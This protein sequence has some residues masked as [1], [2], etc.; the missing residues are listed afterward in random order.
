M[1]IKVKLTGLRNAAYYS[2]AVG[3]VVEIKL[4]EYLRGVVAAEMGNA[5]LE[6]CKAQ[7]VASRT[8]AYPYYSVGKVISDSSRSVQCFNAERAHS[9]QYPNAFQAVADTADEV[10]QYNGKVIVPCSFSSSN[11]GRTTSSQERWGGARAWLI[12]QKDEWDFAAT[13]GKK[14]GHGVGMSQAGAKYAAG[15]GKS[16]EEILTFYYPNTTLH[17]GVD[18]MA[19][20]T[21]KASYL[22][23]S[24]KTM[25]LPWC[26]P[27]QPWKYVASGASEGAVDC[28]GAFTYWYKQAGSF[29]YHGSNTMWRKYTTA[30]GAIRSIELVPGMAV[31]KMRRDGKEPDAYKADG[32]G[33]YYH[34]GLYIGDGKVI[35]A[36]STKTGV[37]TSCISSWG[38]A[39]R[40]KYTAYDLSDDSGDYPTTGTVTTAG[41]HLN[42]RSEPDKSSAVLAKIPN[43]TALTV[44]GKNGSWY[45]VSYNGKSGY[46]AAEYLSL[47]GS[48]YTLT[49]K[50]SSAEIKDKIVSYANGLGV[51]FTVTGGDD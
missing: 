2:V 43:G 11:G 38:Y 25:A 29:M 35:E 1:K 47:T 10:L 15:I 18:R 5:P 7:A 50:T 6:A 34:V 49:G 36:Q 13:Q 4:E 17:K 39:A 45:A 24:F 12:K 21:V 30:K 14:T 20:A 33:N 46:V 26:S 31:F 51:T 37:V 40:L 48:I 32:L 19:Y 28:S 44:T 9:S 22:V 27:K 23:K 3:D 8:T 16:Y 42:L 41:G